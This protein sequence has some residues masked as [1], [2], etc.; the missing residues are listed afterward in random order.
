MNNKHWLFTN[1]RE[2]NP[3]DQ[4]KK[5]LV[6]IVFIA[7]TTYM[8]P[9]LLPR[10]PVNGCPQGTKAVETKLTVRCVKP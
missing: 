8:I 6:I 10:T 5:W 2:L 1:L 9:I 4:L 3:E 7:I